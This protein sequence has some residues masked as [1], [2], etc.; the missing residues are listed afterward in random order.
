MACGEESRRECALPSYRGIVRCY[1][2]IYYWNAVSNIVCNFCLCVNKDFIIIR[3]VLNCFRS[4]F[5]REKHTQIGHVYV[6]ANYF[7]RLYF[8]QR[9]KHT[10][11]FTHIYTHTHTH[12]N[13]QTYIYT[14]T[15]ISTQ[16]YTNT[17][18][19]NKHTQTHT[20]TQTYT[21]KHTQTYTHKNTYTSQ[22]NTHTHTLQVCVLCYICH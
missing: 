13:T 2:I 18:T 8:S 5:I 10:H 4:Y 11:T 9:H 14:Q 12:T 17:N 15:H 16:T 20:H 7:R 1:S 3:C 22:T 21:H 6:T 19:H